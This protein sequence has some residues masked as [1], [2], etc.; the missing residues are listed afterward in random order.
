MRTEKISERIRKLRERSG[1][2]QKA[3]AEKI[4]V[5]NSTYR[6]WEYG[7]QI[8]GEPYVKLAEIFGVSLSTLLTGDT[9]AN[10]NDIFYQIDRVDDL[11][12]LIRKT[13][14]SL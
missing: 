1:L 8:V 10:K 3:I 4:A 2:T 11:I 12:K 7:K 6:D 13:V 14:R 5:P 9:M